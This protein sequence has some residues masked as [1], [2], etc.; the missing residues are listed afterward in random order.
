[1]NVKIPDYQL[2]PLKKFYRPY[3]SPRF[4]SYEMD[5]AVASFL[6]NNEEAK[7]RSEAKKE[8]RIKKRN[9]AK[10]KTRIYKSLRQFIYHKA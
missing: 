3:F 1:M 7:K 2:K 8:L 10:R 9:D 6:I 5:Y 4:N